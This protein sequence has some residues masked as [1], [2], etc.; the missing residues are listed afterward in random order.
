[1]IGFKCN[2]LE[3]IGKSGEREKGSGSVYWECMCTCGRTRLLTQSKLKSGTV[4]SCGCLGNQR[5]TRHG[6]SGTR[7]YSCWKD[8]LARCENTMHRDYTRYGSRGIAV[9][10][11]W[12]VFQNF[13]EWALRNG[14]SNRL[15]IDRVDN[16]LGYSPEN[17]RWATP[18]QQ[19]NNRRRRSSIVGATPTLAKNLADR[20]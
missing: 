4:K 10:E 13:L 6:F 19:A 8:M 3:V 16:D 2:E 9:C 12:H 7:I 14:Y 20:A 18:K 5:N 15:T 1:M 17:C 11:A